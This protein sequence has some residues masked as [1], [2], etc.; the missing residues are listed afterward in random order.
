MEAKLAVL[1]LIVPCVLIL[2]ALG[3]VILNA[4]YTHSEA[5]RHLIGYPEYDDEDEDF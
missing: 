5:V 4:V 3:D 2:L 1:L